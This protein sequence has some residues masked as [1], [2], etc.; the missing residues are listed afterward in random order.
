MHYVAFR[1]MHLLL[2]LIILYTS[3][4]LFIF[5]FLIFLLFEFLHVIFESFFPGYFLLVIERNEVIKSWFLITKHLNILVVNVVHVVCLAFWDVALVRNCLKLVLASLTF[6]SK[7]CLIRCSL[8]VYLL[9][10]WSLWREIKCL[11]LIYIKIQISSL[12]GII[13]LHSLWATEN[14]ISF[15]CRVR[16]NIELR[17]EGSIDIILA[18]NKAISCRNLW[19]H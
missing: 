8:R 19:A 18:L 10:I 5:F 13:W 17:S 15:T 6:L 9:Q 4:Q 16:I 1:C 2:N 3:L 12:I 11:V 7:T 14:N